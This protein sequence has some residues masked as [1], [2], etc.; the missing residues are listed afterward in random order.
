M[1]ETDSTMSAAHTAVIGF[2]GLGAIG[3][4]MAERMVDGG[5]EVVVFNRSAAPTL[6][7]EGRAHIA[8]SP[9]EVGNRADHVFLCLTDAAAYRSVIFGEH[10]LI[11]GNRW[12]TYVHTGTNELAV[13]REI[14]AALAPR[15]IATIDAPITGGVAGARSGKLTAMAAGPHQ[16]WSLV[17]PFMAHY[18]SKLI[19]LGETVG[20]AQMMK[21]INN[22]LSAANLA[23][24]AE[25]FVLGRKAGLD[26]ATMIEV[27]NSGSGQ[28]SA[29]LTKLPNA[30]LTRKFDHGAKLTAMI[31][32]LV[33]F[34]VE[35]GNLGVP[36][37]LAVSVLASFDAAAAQEGGD[38]DLTTVI[39]PMERAARLT[40]G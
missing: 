9:A 11:H 12:R 25:A 1:E 28:N 33:A 21:L 29:T 37:P 2:I 17:R 3:S 20:T 19:Y 15:G 34:S 4:P 40:V 5:A 26:G 38:A 30:I 31:K 7:F 27:L 24:A 13:I 23:L 6:R 39:R 14:E 32:D 8:G 35:A 10:G 36:I 16:V 18:A 22:M